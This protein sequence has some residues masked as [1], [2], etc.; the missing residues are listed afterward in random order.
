MK[1][2]KGKWNF[3]GGYINT[4][5]GKIIASLHDKQINVPLLESRVNFYLMTVAPEMRETLQAFEQW[6]RLPNS[7]RTIKAIEPTIIRALEIIEK[8]EN[9]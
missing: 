8:S 1:H 3:D 6:W 7:K 4:K 5:S 9:I 2:T